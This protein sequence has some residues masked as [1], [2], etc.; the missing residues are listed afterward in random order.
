MINTANVTGRRRGEKLLVHNK[1]S[2]HHYKTVSMSVS[3][4]CYMTAYKFYGEGTSVGPE[5]HINQP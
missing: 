2:F 3:N 1:S 4:V 5:V